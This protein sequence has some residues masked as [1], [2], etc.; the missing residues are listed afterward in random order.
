MATAPDY[1]IDD[2][3]TSVQTKYLIPNSQVLFVN[4][5]IIRFLD[6]SLR[7][8]IIPL[9]N[10]VREEFWVKA[11][12][13]TIV[14]ATKSYS[15]PSRAA[16]AILRDVVFV[17]N[18][19]NEIDMQ[20]L[21]PVQI[22]STFPFGFQLPLY[23]FGYYPQ[24][25]QMVLYPSQAQNATQ[26]TLRMKALRRPNNLVL[27]ANC[28]QITVINGSIITLNVLGDGTWTTATTFDIIPN[29]PQFVS[30]ADAV[31]ITAINSVAL[32]IT[33]TAVP[34]GLSVGDWVCPSLLSCVPQIPYEA[35]SLLE[36]SAILR[37]AEALGDQS[38]VA[39]AQ[40]RFDQLRKDF[41]SLCSPRIQ[42]GTKKI[43]NRNSPASW[44]VVG[45]PF[46]R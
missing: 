33:L 32:T 45:T 26:Y 40:K 34:T 15:I 37:I 36:Q 41:I 14:S 20:R 1:T 27:K 29:S 38:S 4:T 35:F 28:G 23:T 46:L 13:T 12:D 17:D 5:D 3:V 25:D 44:G 19:G 10:S 2:A 18:S 22:K 30:R 39:I 9:I 42:G 31:T 16:G 8:V 11:Y 21:S 6:E 7:D 43:V 24:D